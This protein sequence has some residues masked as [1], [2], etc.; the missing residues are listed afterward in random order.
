[1]YVYANTASEVRVHACL[2]RIPKDGCVPVWNVQV[3]AVQASE[4][5][6]KGVTG[7]ETCRAGMSDTTSHAIQYKLSW[8]RCAA[9]V[10]SSSI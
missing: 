5:N 8:I 7:L 10:P 9:F 4:I 6:A 1:M 2:T 3:V